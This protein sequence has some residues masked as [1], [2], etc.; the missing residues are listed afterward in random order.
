[1][2]PIVFDIPEDIRVNVIKSLPMVAD[3]QNEDLR[4]KVVDAWAL[5]LFL[6]G[7]KNIDEM[8]GSGRPG[9]PAVGNQL[10]HIVA[11]TKLTFKIIDIL[12]EA[13]QTS[14]NLDKDLLLACSLCHDV[15]K[16][17]EYSPQNRDR[18]EADPDASGL[19]SL[20]HTLYGVYIAQTVGLP[21]VVV[22]TAGCHSP[23]GEFVHRALYTALVHIADDVYWAILA[24]VYKWKDWPP[25]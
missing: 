11:S 8:P 4:E 22:H 21:E 17:Y 14:F 7:Y 6:N 24:S 3:I 16:P 23:E 2:K 12:E 1:M 10:H 9:Y 13:L 15:G 18:W 20:R 25:K 19:P 5:S